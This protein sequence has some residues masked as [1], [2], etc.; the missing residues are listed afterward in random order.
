[1][2]TSQIGYVGCCIV[3]WE[4][5]QPGEI[6]VARQSDPSWTPL[7]VVVAGVIANTGSR[8]TGEVLEAA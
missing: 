7:F 3:A 5:F 4:S 2:S 6:L 1:M 8:G